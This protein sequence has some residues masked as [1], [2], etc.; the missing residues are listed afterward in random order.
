MTAIIYKLIE[1]RCNLQ[2]GMGWV[3]RNF[4]FYCKLKVIFSMHSENFFYRMSTIGV[5]M[6]AIE[7]NNDTHCLQ[8][9]IEKFPLQDFENNGI[10]Y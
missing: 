8:T 4:D 6:A 7:P 5:T 3:W 10:T 1:I 2:K 9:R